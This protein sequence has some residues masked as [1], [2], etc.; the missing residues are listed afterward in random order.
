MGTSESKLDQGLG[1]IYHH[2]ARLRDEAAGKDELE[3]ARRYLIGT[4][5]IDLQR[6]GARAMLMTLG[7]LYRLGYDDYTRYGERIAAVSAAD[8]QRVA[9]D[10]LRPEGLVEVV[11]GP[12]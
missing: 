10:Y 6:C 5:A 8:V 1:G 9:R 11:V 3:R 4:H 7:E 12:V 2:L